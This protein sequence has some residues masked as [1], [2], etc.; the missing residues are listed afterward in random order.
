MADAK[1]A[2]FHGYGVQSGV[3]DSILC[4]D[5]FTVVYPLSRSVVLH[6]TETRAMAFMNEG[7]KTQLLA[8]AL[9]PS[10]KYLAL[11]EGGEHAQ[12]RAAPT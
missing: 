8:L 1:L 7:E 2:L 3:Q 9:A 4:V 6:N 12:V 5:E 10:K 11:C